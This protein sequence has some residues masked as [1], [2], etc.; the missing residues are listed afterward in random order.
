MS[1]SRRSVVAL[2]A[3]V[4]ALGAGAVSAASAVHE[5]G[6]GARLDY[7]AEGQIIGGNIHV[8][9]ERTGA[10]TSACAD[11]AVD[12]R[13]GSP[14]AGLH[15][16]AC[17]WDVPAGDGQ[18]FANFGRHIADLPLGELADLDTSPDGA[19]VPVTTP[20]REGLNGKAGFENPPALSLRG[21]FYEDEDLHFVLEPQTID[22]YLAPGGDPGSPWRRFCGT[23]VIG[24][25]NNQDP[26]GPDA[27]PPVAPFA[28]GQVRPYL[29]EVFDGEALGDSSGGNQ[30]Y[31]VIDI[32]APDSSFDPETCDVRREEKPPPPPE[33]PPPPDENPR[34]NPNPE[35]QPQQVPAPQPVLQLVPP[36]A[37][38]P[39]ARRL[40]EAVTVR[41]GTARLSARTGCVGR[42]FTARVR[43]R[44]IRAV[45][46]FLDGRKVRI[47]TRRD[48]RG[49]FS[50]RIDPRRMP[51]G[52]HRL[53]ARARF[54]RAS[55]TRAKTM[56]LTFLR[57]QRRPAPSF[58]G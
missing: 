26:G 33:N 39:R 25:F 51:A 16:D 10:A 9:T 5:D 53:T 3:A 24:Q 13:D 57:C 50:L 14:T 54:Q 20:T 11:A 43:G 47:V 29:V 40:V 35:P 6:G 58:T 46:F 28:V 27:H 23:G 52:A 45:D 32:Y 15:P 18:D 49:A 1:R 56:R 38:A 37:P 17:A 48:R 22:A 36:A 8:V 7:H 34:P 42:A 12:P 4:A 41:P 30:D 31:W 19:F 44:A 21:H 55:R 2:C